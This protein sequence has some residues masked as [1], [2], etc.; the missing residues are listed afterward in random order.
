[1]VEDWPLATMDYQTMK[2]SEIHPTNIFKERN[3]FMGQTVGINYSPDQR[4]YY[5]HRQTPEEV[6]MIKI[7]DSKD[8]VAKC[9]YY[10]GERK[11][12]N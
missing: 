12:I 11:L 4:W 3:E 1:M 8:D 10:Y 7:W 2:Q 5:L 6:T 9:R